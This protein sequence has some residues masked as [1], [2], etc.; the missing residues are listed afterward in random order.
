ME[1]IALT[2][3][4]FQVVVEKAASVLARGGLVVYPTETVYGLA[5]D[6]SDSSAVEKLLSVKRRPVGKAISVLVHG[7][8]LAE[9][10]LQSNLEVSNAIASLLPGP[11]TVVGK[12]VVG[13]VDSRLLSENATLGVRISNHPFAQALATGYGKPITATSANDAGAPRPYSIEIAMKHFSDRQRELIDLVIDAGQLPRREPSTVV[14]YSSNVQTIRRAGSDLQ[15]VSI[16]YHSFSEEETR[17]FAVQVVHSLGHVLWE[18]PVVLALSGEMGSGKTR[19]AQ[20]VGRALQVNRPIN[21]PSYT[22]VKEYEGIFDNQDVR[23]IHVD[24]WRVEDASLNSLGLLEYIQPGIVLV[25]EWPHPLLPA[26]E[27]LGE[28]IVLHHYHFEQSTEGL[29]ITLQ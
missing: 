12:A 5:A 1:V 22:L 18:K 11:V 21:S 20:G 7:A 27:A 25:I 9:S 28:A 23:Y 10:L 15:R 26:L 29:A 8:S 4:N 2:E 24:A 14:D 3:S 16:P 19:F 17:K 6:A 13:V